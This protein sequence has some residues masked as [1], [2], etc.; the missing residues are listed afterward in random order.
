M[1]DVET[2][3]DLDALLEKF[4]WETPLHIFR[5]EE[6]KRCAEGFG[7][8]LKSQRPEPEVV[9]RRQR[10]LLFRD[11]GGHYW[12]VAPGGDDW[13][14][15]RNGK[16]Q[17]DRPHGMLEGPDMARDFLDDGRPPFS[18]GREPP[19]ATD[20]SG[21]PKDVTLS[22]YVNRMRWIYNDYVGGTLN[23]TDARLLLR[24]HIIADVNAVLWNVGCRSG[25]WYRFDGENWQP[26]D[27]APEVDETASPA[28]I[29]EK[30]RVARQAATLLFFASGADILPEEV[31][32]PWAPPEDL[33]EA[34]ASPIE[35]DTCL[36]C[37]AS[38]TPEQRF[39]PQ[40]GTKRGTSPEPALTCVTCGALLKPGNRFCTNCG[41]AV[42]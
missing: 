3:I 25:K 30:T 36:N 10:R 15:Q 8:W 34:F 24:Q 23:S 27:M 13:F 21:P 39:C 6:A 26:S 35:T 5:I 41:A 37:G 4:P 1:S 14:V 17:V 7:K 2:S 38:L 42:S 22:G 28:S 29:D 18:A 19:A 31:A 33:P 12:A 32:E 40:C 11:M 9:A 16:W 20:E